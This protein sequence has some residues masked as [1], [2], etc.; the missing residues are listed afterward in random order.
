MD[1]D[2]EKELIKKAQKDP[3]AFTQ[4]YDEYCFQIFGYILKRVV[5]LMI[6]QNITSETFFKAISLEKY[7]LFSLALQDC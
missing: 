4:F 7:S 1:L 6:A 3:E 2:K 5:D